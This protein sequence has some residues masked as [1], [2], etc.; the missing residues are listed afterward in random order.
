MMRIQGIL[1]LIMLSLGL[2]PSRA[3]AQLTDLLE[4]SGYLKELGQLSISNSLG[5]VRYDNIL[6]HRIETEWNLSSHLEFKA[7]MRTRVLTGYNI[8]HTPGLERRFESDPNF[9]DLSWVW[10]DTESSLM[11]SNIDRLYGSYE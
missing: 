6:H 1:L 10:F 11:H 7:D 2:T 4:V 5:T 8:R 9:A 3:Q